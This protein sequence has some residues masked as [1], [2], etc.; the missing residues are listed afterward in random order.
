MCIRDR[1]FGA[2]GTWDGFWTLF[3]D[4]RADRVFDLSTDWAARLRTTLAILHDDLWLPL[5]GVGLAG[6]WL[7]RQQVP[8]SR[9]QV[10][11]EERSALAP[12]PWPLA[13]DLSRRLLVGLALTLAW[14]PNFA[15]T[16]VSYTHLRRGRDRVAATRR[17]D[18]RWPTAA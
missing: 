6:L 8:G 9:F 1:V 11:G 2:P 4:N 7:N 13:P 5:L 3:F 17:H 16:A 18:R 12:G 14:L 10:P 15:V